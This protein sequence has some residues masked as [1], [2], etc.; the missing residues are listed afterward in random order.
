MLSQLK[1]LARPAVKRAIISTGLEATSALSALGFGK[2]A[3][4][5]GAIFTLHHVRPRSDDAFQPND[6][7]EI[8]PEFLETTILT[9]KAEGYEFARLDDIP[10]RLA[11]PAG[12]PFACFTLDD[13]FRNN[14]EYA[15][16]VFTRHN[17][18]FHIFIAKGFAEATHSMWWETLD[19]LLKRHE[20]LEY[21][22]G[23]GN[24]KIA[25][26]GPA[27]K[28]AAFNRLAGFI[29]RSEETIA[30]AKIDTVARSMG[31]DPLAITR[32]LTMRGDEL[33]ALATNPLVSYGAHTISHRGLSRL[34]P[35]ET[36]REIE[37]SA[38]YLE[39]LTGR[40]PASFAYPYGDARS[41]S[42][43]VRS[44]LRAL[45]VGLSFTTTP[46]VLVS[47]IL[48]DPTAIPRIS[49]NGQYQKARYVR[50]LA[51]GLPFKIMG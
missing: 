50:A 49:L 35:E 9:L 10:A 46:G 37:Q 5:R 1:S 3:R 13:G 18:P 11:E 19:A 21:D 28:L 48:A 2:G 29:N 20:N 27:Q 34:T 40:R 36:R 32:E 31:V 22:F 23:S 6:I 47:S 7:L 41:V 43:G 17:V 45:G 33:Q 30:V 14:A 51:S 42:T 44:I 12:P 39:T 25:A 24:E 15:A 8:T 38:D 16:P 26:H 4:G